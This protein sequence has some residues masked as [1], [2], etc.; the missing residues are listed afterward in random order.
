MCWINGLKLEMG[1]VSVHNDAGPNGFEKKKDYNDNNCNYNYRDY[2][3]N[4]L[5]DIYYARG[6]YNNNNGGIANGS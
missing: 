6:Q 2:N 5:G 4:D 1:L 3:N